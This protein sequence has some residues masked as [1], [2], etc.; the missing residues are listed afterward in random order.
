MQLAPNL[1]RIGS[2]LVN[3]YL[4]ADESGVTL[5]DAGL[6]GHWEELVT[7]LAGMGKTLDDVKALLLT[8]GDT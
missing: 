2:D 7:E 5:I 3:C 1:H 4:V 6:S 8:H